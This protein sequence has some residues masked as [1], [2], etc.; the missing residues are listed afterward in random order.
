MNA[1][2]LMIKSYFDENE[3]KYELEENEEE[4]IDTFQTGF[5]L[6]NESVNIFV[7]VFTDREVYK[8]I[9]FSDS[10]KVPMASING[11]LRAVNKINQSLIQGC[12]FLDTDDG[13]IGFFSGTHTDGLT[14]SEETFGA[15]FHTAIECLDSEVAQIIKNAVIFEPPVAQPAP[16]LVVTPKDSATTKRRSLLSRLFRRK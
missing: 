10:S 5:N 4:K 1:V 2:S 3:W 6:K 13:T 8:I 9:G 12:F 15:S 7:R 16:T 14:F 11:G